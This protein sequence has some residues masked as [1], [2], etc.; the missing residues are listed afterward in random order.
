MI[1]RNSRKNGK[2]FVVQE[3]TFNFFLDLKALQEKWAYNFKEDVNK[4][5]FAWNDIKVLKFEKQDVLNFYFKTSYSETEF[6]KV[7]MRNK[8]KKMDDVQDIVMNR[9]YTNA[10]KLS[11]RKSDDLRYLVENN[12]IPYYY[13]SYY[14]NFVYLP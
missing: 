2:P 1:I 10:F 7:C 3:L 8:R 14:K 5:V 13:P 4:K 12:L 11:Q 9:L 6:S